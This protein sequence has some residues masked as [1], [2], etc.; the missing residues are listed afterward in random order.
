M[1][2]ADAALVGGDR[3]GLATIGI[4]HPNLTLAVFFTIAEKSDH[5]PIGSPFGGGGRFFSACVLACVTA[6]DRHHPNL[7]PAFPLFVLIHLDL[8]DGVSDTRAVW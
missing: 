3:P 1:E 7:S 8:A 4:H 6:T 2:S 5:G